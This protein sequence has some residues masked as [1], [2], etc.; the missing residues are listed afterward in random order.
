MYRESI[1]GCASQRQKKLVTKVTFEKNCGNRRRWMLRDGVRRKEEKCRHRGLAQIGA[2]LRKGAAVSS[3][4][5]FK[6]HNPVR[7]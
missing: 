5:S 1:A 4:L 3:A 7:S 6:I 2:K